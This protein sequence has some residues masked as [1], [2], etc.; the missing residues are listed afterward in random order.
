MDF[1]KKRIS[2]VRGK[3]ISNDLYGISRLNIFP[4]LCLGFKKRIVLIFMYL[5]IDIEL[6]I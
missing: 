1:V 3:N 2:Y 4:I 6:F 5:S